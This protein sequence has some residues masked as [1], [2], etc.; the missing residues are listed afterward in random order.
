MPLASVGSKM[1]NSAGRTSAGLRLYKRSGRLFTH[2]SACLDRWTSRIVLPPYGWGRHNLVNV[3]CCVSYL[4]ENGHP[5][6]QLCAQ[7]NEWLIDGVTQVPFKTGRC[8]AGWL[9]AVAPLLLTEKNGGGSAATFHCFYICATATFNLRQSIFWVS[10][11][12]ELES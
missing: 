6:W 12:L 11:V 4:H 1:V 7:D 10:I 5:P 9:I 8:L 2:V 3:R